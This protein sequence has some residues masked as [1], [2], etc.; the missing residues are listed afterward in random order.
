M[1]LPCRRD[2]TS[3]TTQAAETP[4]VARG[5]CSFIELCVRTRVRFK[6][7]RWMIGRPELGPGAVTILA[8]ER[9]LDLAMTNQAIGHLGHLRTADQIRR[10]DTAMTGEAGIRSV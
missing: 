9:K 1:S 10:F 5:A 2:D 7:L 6:K 8:T 3:V 4:A